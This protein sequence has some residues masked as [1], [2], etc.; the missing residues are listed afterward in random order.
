MNP[1]NKN[2]AWVPRS[3]VWG[4]TPKLQQLQQEKH[5]AHLEEIGGNEFKGKGIL[6]KNVKIKSDTLQIDRLKSA[7]VKIIAEAASTLIVEIDQKK[8]EHLFLK[9]KEFLI[10]EDSVI[11][12]TQSYSK[13][14]YLVKNFNTE[15]E[16][17]DGFGVFSISWDLDI[18]KDKEGQFNHDL[19]VRSWAFLY[20]DLACLNKDYENVLTQS[21]EVAV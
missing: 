19:Q 1:E 10:H 7:F 20:E 13:S 2:S 14:I 17:I 6:E 5:F 21:L 4:Y 3:N 11:P 18:H 8:I 15:E 16:T 9:T 12:F